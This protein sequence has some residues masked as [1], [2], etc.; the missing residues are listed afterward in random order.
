M[1]SPK[2][3]SS[4]LQVPLVGRLGARLAISLE[5]RGVPVPVVTWCVG[6]RE[7]QRREEN[8]LIT[9]RGKVHCLH[10]LAGG[11]DLNQ[12]VTVR[13]RNALGEDRVRIPVTVYRGDVIFYPPPPILSVLF[14]IIY[15]H[16]Y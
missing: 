7:I 15:N 14:H 1:F 2:I 3:D 5:I 9:E 4:R 16:V 11:E 6:R 13:A 12:G 8:Y 10:V